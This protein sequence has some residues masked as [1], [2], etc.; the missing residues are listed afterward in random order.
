MPATLAILSIVFVESIFSAAGVTDQAGRWEHKLLSV[1]VLGAINGANS[2]STTASTR[3]NNFF[4]VTKFVS[5][6][7]VV[8]AGA[9][10]VVLGTADPEKDAGG[11][12]WAT[13]PWF[14]FRDSIAPDGSTIDWGELSTW[15]TLGHY[16]T[17]LYGALWAYSGWDKAS[18]NSSGLQ[19]I[20][21]SYL[22]ANYITA[23][24][25]SPARQLPLAINTAIPVI[26][27]SF[28][29]T[30]TAYYILLPWEIVATTDSVAVVCLTSPELLNLK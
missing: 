1:L 29:A 13:K 14:R 15:E 3:L 28:I 27:A 19:E 20:Q 4:V 10:V 22:Q 5:I 6:A 12:D 17:A 7:G 11:G 16:S 30:N 21:H 2:I 8:V 26:I 25:S 18:C 9:V 23:E 24:L